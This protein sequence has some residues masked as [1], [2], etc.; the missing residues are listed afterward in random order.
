MHAH[1]FVLDLS[2]QSE[3]FQPGL[4]RYLIPLCEVSFTCMIS[5]SACFEVYSDNF[6]TQFWLL[7]I[8]PM[9]HIIKASAG[10][11]PDLWF[12]LTH[13][14]LH[15]YFNCHSVNNCFKYH[16]ISRV[17]LYMVFQV[18]PAWK[19]ERI[20]VHLSPSYWSMLSSFQVYIF[21]TV[22]CLAWHQI[23]GML[24]PHYWV[25]NQP[26]GPVVSCSLVLWLLIS[27]WL[28]EKIFYSYE[29]VIESTKILP[30]MLM[31]VSGSHQQSDLLEGRR[32][33]SIRRCPCLD[34]NY[35]ARS[36]L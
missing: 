36:V 12:F 17:P 3:N 26:F 8:Q 13:P 23:G 32:R 15:L 34:Q 29:V 21:Q 35:I 25:F 27:Y 20:Q 22:T 1:T 33:H 24:S 28:A 5:S 14:F 9:S 31:V 10:A 4:G 6:L 7:L 19:E 16:T 11:E 30:G 18:P 2:L